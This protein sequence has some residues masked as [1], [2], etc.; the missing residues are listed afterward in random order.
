M[1]RGSADCQTGVNHSF[2]FRDELKTKRSRLVRL[3]PRL[4]MKLRAA[5]SRLDFPAV[6]A[7]HSGSGSTGFYRSLLF[8]CNYPLVFPFHDGMCYS[9]VFIL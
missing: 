3:K 1:K 6:L 8:S 9:R 4:I 2:P 7:F 5:E